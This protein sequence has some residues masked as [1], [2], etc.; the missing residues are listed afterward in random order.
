MVQVGTNK[1]ASLPSIAAVV[2][3]SSR[4]VGSPS[5]PSSPSGAVRIR[6]YIA[7]VGRVTVSLRRSTAV[8]WGLE[9]TDMEEAMVWC[10]GY[11]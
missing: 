6:S 4:T 2:A 11:R 10:A 1:P 9:S 5:R 3:S 7:S 8:A